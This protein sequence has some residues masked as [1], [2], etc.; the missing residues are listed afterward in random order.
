LSLGLALIVLTLNGPGS[1]VFGY[2][3]VTRGIVAAM[4]ADAGADVATQLIGPLT[5]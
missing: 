2:V 4:W 3:F 5:R 1:A